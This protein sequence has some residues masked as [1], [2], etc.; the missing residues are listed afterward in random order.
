MWPYTY[1][2]RPYRELRLL[3]A[4][5]L[6]LNIQNG[7]ESRPAMSELVYLLYDVADREFR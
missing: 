4:C 6:F 2:E 7:Y 5:F 1:V 3:T